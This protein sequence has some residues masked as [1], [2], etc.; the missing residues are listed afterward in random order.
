MGPGRPQARQR[1]TQPRQHADRRQRRQLQRELQHTAD[2]HADRQRIDRLDAARAQHRRAQQRSGDHAEVEQH[3]SE[4]WHRKPAPGVEHARGQ[5]DHRHETDVGK[6]PTR[7]HRRGIFGGRCETRCQQ[8]D[9][10]R[11]GGDTDDTSDQQRP[12]QH[13]GHRVDQQARGV[14]T[15]GAAGGREQRH[16][17]LRESALCE[18]ASQQVGNAKSDLERIHHR[19]GAE[20]RGTDLLAHQP[21]DA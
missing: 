19:R 16:E 7:H 18:Q 1:D 15:I 8:P 20:H 17:G 10:H 13:G 6:H 11:R 4:C 12:G 3:R 21:G 14:V 5:C 9:Q 2:H